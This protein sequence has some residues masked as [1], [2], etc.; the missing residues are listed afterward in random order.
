MRDATMPFQ[1][2][3]KKYVRK[4]Y[5]K[6]GG[7]S[8]VILRQLKILIRKLCNLKFTYYNV[9]LTRSKPFLY[10]NQSDSFV[11]KVVAARIV[12]AEIYGK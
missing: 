8:R 9:I 7:G 4:V 11:G 10:I 1:Q 2:S 12:Q 5:C 6:T 3:K